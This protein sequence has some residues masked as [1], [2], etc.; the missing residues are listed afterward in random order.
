MLGAIS[1][2][3]AKDL[4]VV[5]P[6]ETWVCALQAYVPIYFKEVKGNEG[7]HPVHICIET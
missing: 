3:I 5:R 7:S 4:A 1:I 6:V 2:L